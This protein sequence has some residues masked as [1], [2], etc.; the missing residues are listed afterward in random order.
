MSATYPI[1]PVSKERL[2]QL[3]E[4]E[5]KLLR[6]VVRHSMANLT[7]HSITVLRDA[8]LVRAEIAKF[9]PIEG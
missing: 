7:S 3:L 4:E 2:I 8:D 6:E 9:P 1:N 5:A